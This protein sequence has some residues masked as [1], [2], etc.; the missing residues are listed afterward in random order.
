MGITV[1][2]DEGRLRELMSATG[3]STGEDAVR[4][5]IEGVLRGRDRAGILDLEGRV[6]F[7]LDW[8]EMERLELLA[9]RDDD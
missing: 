8:R 4:Q 2:I 6:E 3:T 9:G 1:E 7:D 5:A